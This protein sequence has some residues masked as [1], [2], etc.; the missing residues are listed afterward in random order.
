VLPSSILHFDQIVAFVM[1]NATNNDTLVEHFTR[2]CSEKDIY[3]S[4]IDGRLRCLPHTIHLAALKVILSPYTILMKLW[5]LLEAL[6]ALT[7]TQKKNAKLN[8][9]S[10][11][12]ETATESV[13]RD[14]D[15]VIVMIE[16]TVD[17]EQVA[18]ASMIGRAI[19]KVGFSLP[20]SLLMTHFQL[21]KIVRYVRSSPQRRAG[22]E[23]E[24]EQTYRNPQPIPTPIPGPP[25]WVTLML[26]LDVVTRWSSTHQM[27]REFSDCPLFI[28]HHFKGVPL[29]TKMQSITMWPRT[30]KF[31]NTSFHFSTGKRL[32]L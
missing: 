28:S 10:S 26:I 2:H 16:D 20:A 12:Q 23:R 8:R 31:D 11:Y 14:Q 25:N 32:S 17:E 1:D 29:V 13:S 15:N 19:F 24:V 22:W 4:E 21:R 9:G 18:P 7:K 27:L 5:Q 30:G 3:F 6:G